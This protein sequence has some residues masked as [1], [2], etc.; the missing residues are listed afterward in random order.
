MFCARPVDATWRTSSWS[1]SGECIEV[2]SIGTEVLIRDSK[3]RRGSVLSFSATAWKHFVEEARRT[4][5]A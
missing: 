5:T 4:T 1:I 2:G 3:N